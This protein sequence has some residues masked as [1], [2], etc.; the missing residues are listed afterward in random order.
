MK[1]ELLLTKLVKFLEL[2]KTQSGGSGDKDT[3]ALT[4]NEYKAVIAILLYFQKTL[5]RSG[6]P[7]EKILDTLKACFQYSERISKG[8]RVICDYTREKW[9]NL[10]WHR[11]RIFKTAPCYSVTDQ[12]LPLFKNKALSDLITDKEFLLNFTEVI[13]ETT[14][15][16]R[17]AF[18]PFYRYLFSNKM[19]KFVLEFKLKN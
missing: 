14:G 1:T 17:K 2:R 16:P 12:I 11:K 15:T 4:N 19:E 13:N 18:L 5:E 8:D 10:M 3:I 7:Q 6:K 9:K